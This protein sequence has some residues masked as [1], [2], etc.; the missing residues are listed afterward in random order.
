MIWFGIANGQ[1]SSVFDRVIYPQQ[2]NG[3]VVS[4]YV[5]SWWVRP[6]GGVR[7]NLSRANKILS[8]LAYTELHVEMG[9]IVKECAEVLVNC[10][11]D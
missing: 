10:L 5:F 6:G 11:E 7:K 4:F 8:Y 3:G 2:G 9:R 1:I